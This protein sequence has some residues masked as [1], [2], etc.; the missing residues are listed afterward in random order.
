MEVARI[1]ITKYFDES[2][3]GAMSVRVEYGT[4]LSLIDALGMIAFAQATTYETYSE[5]DE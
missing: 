5:D 3:E 1:V 4:N 2:A